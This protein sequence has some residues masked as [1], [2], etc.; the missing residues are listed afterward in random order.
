[1]N[2][3]EWSKKEDQVQEQVFKHL[4]VYAP[5][6]SML[7]ESGRAQVCTGVSAGIVYRY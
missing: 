2:A 6:F 4:R 5:L 3:M 7:S 1:M